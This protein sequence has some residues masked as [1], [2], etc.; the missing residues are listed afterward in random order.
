MYAALLHITSIPKFGQLYEIEALVSEF[1]VGPVVW[2][3][4]TPEYRDRV[5]KTLLRAKRFKYVIILFIYCR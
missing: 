2:S 3:V 5:K 1:K 4:L